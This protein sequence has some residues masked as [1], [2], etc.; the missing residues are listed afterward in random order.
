[1]KPNTAVL[2]LIRPYWSFNMAAVNS[3]RRIEVS[4]TSIR[5]YWNQYGRI[6]VSIQ[7]Q[8]T[9]YGRIEISEFQYGR[10]ELQYDRIEV[11]KFQY[12]RIAPVGRIAPIPYKYDVNWTSFHTFSLSFDSLL[13][14][15]GVFEQ[16][17]ALEI[18][19]G[20]DPTKFLS[21]EPFCLRIEPSRREI[22]RISIV[23]SF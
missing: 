6:E 20:V 14:Y 7:P 15:S 8:W 2:N 16:C 10:I 17:S 12:G 5:P 11:Q 21:P 19:L 9:Q 4:E 22:L 18:S 1:M 3:I 23:K 13:E